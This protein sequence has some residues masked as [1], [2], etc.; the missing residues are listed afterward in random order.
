MATKAVEPSGTKSDIKAKL[1]ALEKLMDEKI[2]SLEA[3]IVSLGNTHHVVEETVKGHAARFET[4]DESIEGHESRLVAVEEAIPK[5]YNS[6]MGYLYDKVEQLENM[7][8]TL[9]KMAADGSFGGTPK[10][11]PPTPLKYSGARDSKEVDNFIFDM[12]QYFRVSALDEGLKVSTASMYLT[13]DAKQWWRSKHAEIEA[14]NIDFTSSIRDYVKAYSACMLEIADMTEKD[15]VFQFIDGLKEWA[16]REIM[17]QRPESLATAMTAAERLVDYYTERETSQKKGFA[18][19]G[20]SNQRGPH[21]MSECPHQ[22][23]FNTFKKNL[24]KMSVEQNPEGIGPDAEGCDD[25]EASEQG[26]MARMGAV[27]MMCSMDKGAERSETKSTLI[28]LLKLTESKRGH[29]SRDALKRGLQKGEPTYLCTVSMKED[30]FAECVDPQVEKVLE[31]NKDLM[32]DQLPMSLPPRRSVD[33]QIELLPGTRPPARGPYRMAPPELAELR[34]QLDDL[35]RSGSIRP[36]KAPYGAHVLFQKKQDGSL[37]LCIDYRLEQADVRNR[38]PIPLVADLFDQLQG[39][40]YF[41]KLDLRSGYHQ[42]RIAEGDE[43]K[44]ACVTSGQRQTEDG[45]EEDCRYQGLGTLWNVSELR[46]FLGLANYYR[47]F[48]R[49]YSKIASPLTDLLK[50]DTK[51]EWSIDKKRPFEKLKEAVVQEP[52]LALPDI[53]KPFEVE[54]D[55]SYYALGGVLLQEGHP[56]AFE[57][58]K[59]NGAETRYAVQEK[60][61]LAIVHC[62]RGWRHYLLGSKFVVKTDN[63]AASHFLT[64]PK[65]TSRQARW[66]ELLA[67]SMWNLL[68]HSEPQTESLMP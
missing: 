56:V 64:Q 31:E 1:A 37:R 16:Q 36:S 22:G 33:H 42:V 68:T 34:R 23:E 12:E 26:E 20:G 43:P 46:S 30:T 38:Y 47:R 35:I 60:E 32:P 65:L 10:V 66:Q 19:T 15:R 50:K 55:A 5:E 9:M 58:R 39:A 67:S 45:P 28:D 29:S 3:L 44:T 54:T 18:A 13:D 59:F 53:T 27:H 21:R 2:P 51:W 61:L 40:V 57:S 6:D 8:N 7:C 17:R 25:D 24:S 48:I 52:V 63:T 4:V 41:T 49:A 14:G 62:L 11:K